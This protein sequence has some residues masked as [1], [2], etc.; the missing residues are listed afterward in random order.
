MLCGALSCG[1]L[2]TLALA[3]VAVLASLGG[4]SHEVVH[5]RRSLEAQPSQPTPTPTPTP[6]AAEA[7]MA[8]L[9]GVVKQL[10]E[11]QRRKSA[12]AKPARGA[13]FRSRARSAARGRGDGVGRARGRGGPAG[14]RRAASPPPRG[15][16]G[17]GGGGAGG[18]AGG[19]AAA[20]APWQARG[21]AARG[22]RPT[23]RRG[24]GR[25]RASRAP[26]G[27]R[28]RARATA[29]TTRGS[30]V[31]VH[32]RLGGAVVHRAAA[33]ELQPADR[34]GRQAQLRGGVPGAPRAQFSAQFVRRAIRRREASD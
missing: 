6:S 8:R 20:P 12:A 2:S 24:S 18:A 21:A 5:F 25:R 1:A 23:R 31:P 19:Q 9:E 10:K 17:G 3:L 13:F 26:T 32:R 4:S 27:R 15:G 28:G 14:A 7:S 33:A 30:T 29:C 34:P 22:P 11:L 16:G